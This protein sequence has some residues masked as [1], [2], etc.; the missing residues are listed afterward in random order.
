MK[1]IVVRECPIC[2]NFLKTHPSLK[3]ARLTEMKQK[4][5]ELAISF[6]ERRQG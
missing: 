6:E 4:N 1:I 2:I 5:G 3:K